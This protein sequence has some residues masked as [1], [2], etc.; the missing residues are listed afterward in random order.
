MGEGATEELIS[1]WMVP[2]ASG[3]SVKTQCLPHLFDRAVEE[4]R[5]TPPVLLGILVSGSKGTDSPSNVSTL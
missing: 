1:W 5:A 3:P 2:Q 4:L